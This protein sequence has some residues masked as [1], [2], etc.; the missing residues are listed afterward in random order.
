MILVGYRD[1]VGLHCCLLELALNDLFIG[2][3]QSISG[4][5]FFC[6][7]LHTKDLIR[8]FLEVG[9]GILFQGTEQLPV[10]PCLVVEGGLL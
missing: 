4:N 7:F 2:A 3:N 9:P 10:Y 6:F 8:N 1:E 5:C